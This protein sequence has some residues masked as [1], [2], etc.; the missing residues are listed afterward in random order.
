MLHI[1]K[2]EANPSK[3]VLRKIHWIAINLI[4]TNQ[5]LVTGLFRASIILRR[6]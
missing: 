6:R 5:N 3:S 4:N 2:G 1:R